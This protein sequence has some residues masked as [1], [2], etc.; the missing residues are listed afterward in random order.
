M[1]LGWAIR[2]LKS[3]SK[4]T[5]FPNYWDIYDVFTFGPDKL[6]RI[7]DVIYN[8]FWLDFIKGFEAL[9]KTDII[10]QM[11]IIHEVPISFNPNLRINLKKW[12]DNGIRI[13]NDNL[14]LWQ[15]NEH[16]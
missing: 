13:L 16:S 2:L 1:K 3:E 12:F 11:D 7:K 14:Y 8:P 15:A 6:D 5:V 9:F 10:T 4:W